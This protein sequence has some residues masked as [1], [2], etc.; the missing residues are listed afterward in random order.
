[1]FVFLFLFVSMVLSATQSFTVVNS[2][3]SAWSFSGGATG[4]N[5]SL[6]ASV[7]DTLTF[8]VTAPGHSFAIHVRSGQPS[9]TQWTLGVTGQPTA[10]GTVTFVIPATAPAQLFYQCEFHAPMTGSITISGGATT[11]PATSSRIIVAWAL[12]A[13]LIAV[14]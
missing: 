5:P 2:G 10:S 7:G 11:A 3:S 14:L 12:I 9:G 6:T 4:N 13:F 8:A 1:M